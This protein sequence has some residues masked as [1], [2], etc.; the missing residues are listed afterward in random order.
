M[1]RTTLLLGVLA[2]GLLLSGCMAM[3]PIMCGPMKHD[4]EPKPAAPAAKADET[5]PA[6]AAEGH[7][8]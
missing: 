5:T 7:K 2:A 4:E 3:M 6:P 8:H 1:K